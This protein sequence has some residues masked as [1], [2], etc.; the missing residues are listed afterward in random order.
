MPGSASGAAAGPGETPVLF[1][2][3]LLPRASV[4]DGPG[5][6]PPA[7][8][9]T[10]DGAP[11]PARRSPRK[12][13]TSSLRARR[14]A[15]ATRRPRTRSS[16]STSRRRGCS[17]RR[18]PTERRSGRPSRSVSGT[19]D[20][21]LAAAT[22]N[23]VA[24]EVSGGAFSVSSFLFEGGGQ[25]RRDRPRRSGGEPLGL[26]ALL[27]REVL[28]ALRRD[29]RIGAPLGSGSGFF[30]AVDADRPLERLRHGPGRSQRDLF[31]FRDLDRRLRR[32]HAVRHGDATP[33][34][35]RRPRALVQG[36]P[37]VGA[38]DR[39]R[40]SRRPRRLPGPTVAVTGTASAPSR[41]SR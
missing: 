41:R 40:R 7:A 12:A 20:P 2:R 21:D 32:L 27:Q 6:A 28:G 22:V 19:S 23:G 35:T 4:S 38:G 8:V 26:L 10:L 5:A 34:A 18:R 25:H 13:R 9:L 16:R 24:A 17:R 33:S 30:R 39:H 15:R 36:G 29:P 14:I 37:H 11:W 1:G 3:A 31:P